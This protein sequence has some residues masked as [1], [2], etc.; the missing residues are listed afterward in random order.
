M[1]VSPDLD[2]FLNCQAEVSALA[3]HDE[4]TS[5]T[6]KA[7]N[8][9]EGLVGPEAEDA[10]QEPLSG[11]SSLCS[12]TVQLATESMVDL[13]PHFQDGDS[14]EQVMMLDSDRH[15]FPQ[16][17]PHQIEGNVIPP[18]PR[19]SLTYLHVSDVPWDHGI[20]AQVE[21]EKGCS[22]SVFVTPLDPST[23][24]QKKSDEQNFTCSQFGTLPISDTLVRQFGADK[25][26]LGHRLKDI[27]IDMCGT[28]CTNLRH[29][30]TQAYSVEVYVCTSDSRTVSSSLVVNV[31]AW[32]AATAC[33]IGS[34]SVQAVL[35]LR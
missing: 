10:V 1:I 5:A 31:K 19:P 18:E 17:L 4:E 34:E 3:Q 24:Q 8:T 11:R 12:E 32:E 15:Y 26:A 30:V 13:I 27:L 9:K 28:I 16:G 25:S 14:K 29:Q 20:R 22:F 23:V 7:S 6:K 35:N 2:D 33:I 21:P